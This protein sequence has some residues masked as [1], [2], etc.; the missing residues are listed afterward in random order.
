MLGLALL[1]LAAL[2]AGHAASA[3][4]WS[5]DGAAPD[6]VRPGGPL[7]RATSTGVLAFA[8]LVAANWALALS[9][10]LT[11]KGLLLAAAALLGAAVALAMRHGSARAPEARRERAAGGA[12]RS[13][14][15]YVAVAA[16]LLPVPAWILYVL[17]RG[18]VLPALSDDALIY[19]LPKALLLSRAGSFRFFDAPDLRISCFPANYELL[20]SDV[21]LLT[22]SDRVT[23]WITTAGY[24][25][26][27]AA[28][29]ALAER[30]W[31]TGIHV[32]A[33][34]LVAGAM[35]VVLLHSGAHKHDLLMTA[36]SLAAIL[37]FSR[38][39]AEGGFAP[40]ALGTVSLALAAGTK[41][42]TASVVVGLLPIVAATLVRRRLAGHRPVLE[43][44]GGTLLLL[45][46]SAVLL[47]GA[48]YAA[49]WI[50][51]GTPFG[52][53]IPGAAPSIREGVRDADAI[54]QFPYLILA[55][56]FSA[57]PWGVWAPW[58]HEYW[59][60]P[61]YDLN[62][63]HWGPTVT[64]LALA[65]PA[66]LLGTRRDVPSRSRERL[67]GSLVAALA[68]LPSMLGPMPLPGIFCFFAR[69]L[70][71]AP[72]VLACLTVAPL[73]RRLSADPARPRAAPL[74]LLALG[75]IFAAE[76]AEYGARDLYAPFWYVREQASLPEGSRTVHQVPTRAA[77]VVDRI[78]GPRDVIAFDAG[79]DS[80]TY[81]AW[82]SRLSRDVRFLP[83]GTTPVPIPA[84]AKFVVVDRVA[85][86]VWGAP[87]F[88]HMSQGDRFLW[89]GTPSAEELAVLRQVDADPRFRRIYL[90]EKRNQA[91]FV[92][93]DAAR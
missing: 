86:T 67:T 59:F 56:P 31:G 93:R 68:L 25:L 76:A 49:N 57:S 77:S 23:E 75:G 91:V 45:L 26:F 27:L 3:W 54:W 20:L 38:W 24:V 46:G 84:D 55:V 50:H 51:T 66:C 62:L 30:W 88:R 72:V 1:A 73:V 90:D 5:L 32:V 87:G 33:V 8:S 69:Y 70:A 92:R 53:S 7:E 11:A 83:G 47:G 80:W 78:A 52:L 61:R 79:H 6:G 39:S 29:A 19:H 18:W 4:L 63:S 44:P 10:Q 82:G 37:W 22:G 13:P 43:R 2:A 48:A 9:G 16:S 21:L 85:D 89:Q 71:F 12:R 42:T 64:V 60:W 40:L 15:T 14:G 35:P 17:W 81:P 58:A 28:A 36:F 65:L 41:M 74:L 34:A